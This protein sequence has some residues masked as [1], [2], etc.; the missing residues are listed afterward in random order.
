MNFLVD[1]HSHIYYDK[2]KDDLSKVIHD[3]EDSEIKRI[4][5]VG[6]DIETSTDLLKLLVSIKMYFAVGCHP[7]DASKMKDGY[8]NEIAEMCKHDKVVAIGETGL[9]YF[10]SHSSKSTQKKYLLIR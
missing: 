6:T 10:Y 9:D 2:Y 5:C 7:H 8:L 1:T 4:I 3:A